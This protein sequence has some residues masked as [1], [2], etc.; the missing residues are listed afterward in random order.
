MI[1]SEVWRWIWLSAMVLFALAE[2]AA[3]GTFFL[4]SFAAG[5]LLAALGAFL[6][7]SVT[8]QWILFVGGSAAALALLVPLGRRLD[9]A[10]ADATTEGAN[11]W[12][13]RKAT[14]LEAI[15]GGVHE[16]GRVRI[17]REEWRAEHEGGSPV[18]VGETVTVVRVDGTRLVVRSENL[19]APVGEP[20][21]NPKEQ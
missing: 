6:G 15:P 13:G 17:E 4:L 8:L 19:D 11:R 12:I 20:T 5:A 7:A 9:R 21:Q 10:K 2:L 3:P 1:D 18:A 14:V 16:T